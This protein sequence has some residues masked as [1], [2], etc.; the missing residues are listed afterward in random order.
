MNIPTYLSGAIFA[1]AQRALRAIVVQSLDKHDLTPTEWTFLGAVSH[2]KNGIRL[3]ELANRLGVKAPL[4]T[5]MANGL[6]EQGYIKRVA[7]PSD[8]RAKLLVITP[9]G[10]AF[11]TKVETDVNKAL[12]NLLVGL[13]DADLEAYKHVLETIIQ[14]AQT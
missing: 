1:K 2:A 13:S 5:F 4:I 9:Q 3:V 14:N 12:Q 8:R 11:V 10:K 6:I 7:H